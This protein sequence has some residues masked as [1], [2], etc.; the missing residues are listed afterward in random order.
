[1]ICGWDK[2][3]RNEGCILQVFWPFFLPHDFVLVRPFDSTWIQEDS[4]A[5]SQCLPI[6]NS[7][8]FCIGLVNIFE[9]SVGNPIFPTSKSFRSVIILPA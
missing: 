2:G 8:E 6:H 5:K 9:Y 3:F 1:M 4:K 7:S